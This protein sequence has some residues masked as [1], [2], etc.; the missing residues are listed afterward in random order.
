MTRASA[1]TPHSQPSQHMAI[2]WFRNDLRLEDNQALLDACQSDAD[3]L[4]PVYCLDIGLLQARPDF[5]DLG[6]IPTLG[7]HKARC[8]SSTSS[9]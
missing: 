5:P 1:T 9:R 7:V 3:C 8:A 4:L 6:G 2:M